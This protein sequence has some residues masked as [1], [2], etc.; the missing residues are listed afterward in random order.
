M[1]EKKG[2]FQSHF[3]EFVKIIFRK[4]FLTAIFST[5][6]FTEDGEIL[7][8]T[9]WKNTNKNI[10]AVNTSYRFKCMLCDDLATN[11]MEHLKANHPESEVYVARPSPTMAEKIRRRT[12]TFT[13]APSLDE[14]SGICFFCEQSRRMSLSDWKD[15]LL[16]HTGETVAAHV[17]AMSNDHKA[18][19]MAFMCK[20]CNYTQMDENR[21]KKH[22]LN[23]HGES[24]DVAD[25][26]YDRVVLIPDLT[27]LKPIQT[28]NIE[29]IDEATRFKCGIGWCEYKSSNY[30][31]FKSHLRQN[32]ESTGKDESFGCSY[33]S[34]IIDSKG[35]SFV[36]DV[37]EHLK[38][39]GKYLF[40]CIFCK[41][42]FSSEINIILHIIHEH[43]MKTIRF[44]HESRESWSKSPAIEEFFAMLRCNKCSGTFNNFVDASNHFRMSHG[45][46]N[47]DY[48]V[49]KL[50]KNTAVNL[51]TSLGLNKYPLTLR[52]FFE[53]SLC[54]ETRFNESSLI[55]HFTK[56][57]RKRSLILKPGEVFIKYVDKTEN[58]D[59]V[60]NDIRSVFYCYVCYE[61]GGQFVGYANSQDV[62]GHWFSTHSEPFRFAKAQ[63]AKCLHCDLMGTYQGLNW[64]HIQ[65]H[66]NE[67]FAM[68]DVIIP[69]KCGLCQHIGQ[70]LDE[71]FEHQHK[72]IEVFCPIPLSN[73]SLKEVIDMKGQKKRRCEHCNE[74]FETKNEFKMHHEVKHPL[75]K[76]KSYKFYDNKTVHM[77]TGCCR[78]RINP[79]ELFGHLIDHK[80]P[81]RCSEC[82]FA[83]SDLIELKTHTFSHHDSEINIELMYFQMLEPFFWK[84]KVIFGNG[85]VLNKHNLVGTDRDDSQQFKE[86]VEINLRDE[87]F[88]L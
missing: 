39:H 12:E 30:S 53:C 4:S 13:C 8:S 5:F 43:P 56:S 49:N 81:T 61:N 18:E 77:I 70:K 83:T 7:E 76:A 72:S 2:Y 46:L 41:Q 21:L 63:I 79:D 84:T 74:V 64:H 86:F 54:D 35:K 25:S 36:R 88:E 3:W 73:A 27:P 62:F 19:L 16:Y 42:P 66:P 20:A 11:L 71:H 51:A 69:D 65:A 40:W 10:Y 45:S 50:I 23:E 28:K 38:L 29:F 37:T 87:L 33:C 26:G 85:L 82:S 48:T 75:F 32:H 60:L 1:K 15:H 55:K 6:F 52:Q 58:D 22:R 17:S 14:I 31:S 24:R 67:T 34:E 47:I 78:K 59:I 68:V 9:G 57:H 44:R 80:F